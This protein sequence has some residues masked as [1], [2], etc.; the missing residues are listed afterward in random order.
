MSGSRRERRGVRD[1]PWRRLV[2]R[3]VRKSPLNAW[4]W[5]WLATAVLAAGVAWG[6]IAL[7]PLPWDA[8]VVLIIPALFWWLFVFVEFGS[9]IKTHGLQGAKFASR[10]SGWEFADEAEL[11]QLAN[12]VYIPGPPR[13]RVLGRN[14]LH[15][16]W[17]RREA[18]VA[19]IDVSA[20]EF[21]MA[22]MRMGDFDVPGM[23]VVPATLLNEFRGRGQSVGTE[24]DEFNDRWTVLTDNP[25]FA[26]AVTAAPMM[27]RLMEDDAEGF[28]IAVEGSQVIVFTPG[29][30]YRRSP[31]RM[32]DFAYSVADAVPDHVW[33]Q[34]GRGES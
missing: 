12:Y 30:E 25:Q 14:V 20:A 13:E 8:A 18:A 22:S 32:L 10:H 2:V 9:A 29:R 24:W 15:G 27:R 5:P 1:N 26:H 3:I 34:W 19:V 11:P 4:V 33:T 17:R 16:P 28:A 21:S 23:A 6:A 31:Q 7:W